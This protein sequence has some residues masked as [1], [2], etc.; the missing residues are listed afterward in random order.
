VLSSLDAQIDAI[1]RDLDHYG[2]SKKKLSR[3]NRL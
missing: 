2:P 1:G 3:M